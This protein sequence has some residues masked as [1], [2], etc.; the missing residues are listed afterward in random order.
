MAPLSLTTN[1]PSAAPGMITG[2]TTIDLPLR[3]CKM[4][5]TAQ[6]VHFDLHKSAGP[7]GHSVV[8]VGATTPTASTLR[9]QKLPW[10]VGTGIGT[11]DLQVPVTIIVIVTN[12]NHHSINCVWLAKIHR[13][14]AVALRAITSMPSIRRISVA[15][16]HLVE[17]PPTRLTRTL[18]WPAQSNI[19]V[20]RS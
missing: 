2:F 3:D 7:R 9:G 17:A 8:I 12:L 6:T 4:R 13:Q 10:T 16:V 1:L 11:I 15:I 14:P 5:S 20:G 19:S 18:N